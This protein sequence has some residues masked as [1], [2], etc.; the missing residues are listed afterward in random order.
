M[1]S[2]LNSKERIIDSLITKEGRRQIANGRLRA[3]FYSFSDAGAFYSKQ[4]TF[5]SASIMGDSITTEM[6]FQIEASSLPQDEVSFEADDSGKLV[7]KELKNVNG[8]TLR[9]LEGIIYSGSTAS[10]N[11]VTSSSDFQSLSEELLQS[12]ID[13]F[14]KLY[15]LGSPSL[16]RT[17]RDEFKISNKEITFTIS[18]NNPISI[19]SVTR[20]KEANIDNIESLFADKRLSHLPNFKFLPP[21]NKARVGTSRKAPLGIFQNLSQTPIQTYDDLKVSFDELEAKGCMQEIKFTETSEKNRI[22]G[23]IFEIG[24]NQIKKLDV[25]DFGTFEVKSKIVN[26]VQVYENKEIT[27]Q[28]I[29]KYQKDGTVILTKR[30]FFVGKLFIDSN[31]SHTF[32]NMFV[33]CFS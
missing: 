5:A 9:L 4:D 19:N 17:D 30:I 23:Q 3:E 24:G 18:D 10:M 14:Q 2:I 11:P 29:E 16:F 15:I 20:A 8:K 1:S 6:P 7:V 28:Q 22:F 27:E 25:I 26:G 21:V 12:S 13:N 32:V 31:G 33:L